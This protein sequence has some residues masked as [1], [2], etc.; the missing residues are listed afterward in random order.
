MVL[1]ARA[2]VLRAR[3]MMLRARAIML[4]ARVMVL[5]ARAMVLRARAMMLRARAMVL[6]ARVMVLRTLCRLLRTL[7]MLLRTQKKPLTQAQQGTQRAT[8]PR[9]RSRAAGCANTARCA[10]L[11][12][13]TSAPRPLSLILGAI[14]D[15]TYGRHGKRK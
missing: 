3:V 12:G 10:V 15:A 4:R 11:I 1:R 13:T 6:R 8:P 2:M 14:G 5:R 9:R 7:C